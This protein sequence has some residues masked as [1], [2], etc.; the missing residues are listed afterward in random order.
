MVRM[1]CRPLARLY[2]KGATKN[3]EVSI[4][5]P[6][7]NVNNYIQDSVRSIV[8]QSFSGEFELVLVN[9]GTKDN[10]IEMALEIL[11]KQERVKYKVVN[12]ENGGLPSARNA[13]MCAASGKYICFIDS[14]DM[15]SKNHIQGLYSC[16]VKKRLPLAYADFEHTYPSNKAGSEVVNEGSELI[17]RKRL[18]EG[19][20]K[21]DLKI[22][23]CSIMFDKAFLEQNNFCFNEKLRYGEDIEFMWR[24]FPQVQ[25]I[26]HIKQKSYKYLQRPN[27]IMTYQSQEKIIILC[28]EFK[29]VV[30][31]NKIHYPEDNDVF[32]YLMGKALLA[33]FRTAAE[34]SSLKVF[35]NLL[36]KIDYKREIQRLGSFE[37]KKIAFLAKTLS[38]SPV[39]FYSAINIYKMKAKK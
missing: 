6:V 34:T 10:S 21:R 14:D 15:I 9:D 28:E 19:F 37:S 7:Y 27:S 31:Y 32:D 12:K 26:G 22:H 4:V 30:E 11:E 17:E 2:W 33:F 16:I 38:F 25:K 29:K 36:S 20:L 1:F 35:C 39:L 8:N 18:L 3:M 24:V 23:C 5:M 13:G